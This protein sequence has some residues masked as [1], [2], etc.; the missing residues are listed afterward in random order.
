MYAYFNCFS[1]RDCK[2]ISQ[3][4]NFSKIFNFC[5]HVDKSDQ[6]FFCALWTSLLNIKYR[7]SF[8]ERSIEVVSILVLATEYLGLF[9]SDADGDNAVK[10]LQ[11]TLQASS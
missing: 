10:H 3:S 9:L 6:I 2:L 4:Q 1:K 11:S 7:L 5:D 8:A